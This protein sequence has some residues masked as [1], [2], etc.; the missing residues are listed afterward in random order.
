MTAKRAML[1]V[2]A[3]N[4][5]LGARNFEPGGLDYDVNKLVGE[6]TG[7]YDFIR[8]Y[9]FDS[10]KPGGYDDKKSFF[11]FLETNGF[12]V[13]AT[14]LGGRAGDF[15]EKEA[16]IR[17]ATELIARGFNDSYDVATVITGDKDFVRA[18]R[19]VQDHGKIVHVVSFEDS[20][21]GALRRTADRYTCIDEIADDI[22]KK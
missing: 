10:Y 15:K 21:S 6:L 5:V 3:Q 8:G 12:R 11:T 4:L 1:F 19:Y 14:E 22:R 20:L 17:L 9:W 2:D 7:D 13:E 16:D 18:I